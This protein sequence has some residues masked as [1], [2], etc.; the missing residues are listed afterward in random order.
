MASGPT[1]GELV[2]LLIGIGAAALLVLLFSAWLAARSRRRPVHKP[3]KKTFDH[4]R[5]LARRRAPATVA[6]AL[7]ELVD[8]PVGRAVH[9]RADEHRA[10]VTLA[11][12]RSQPCAQAAGYLA[13]LFESAWAHEVLVTHP[14]CAG[15]RGGE[16]AYVVQRG[17]VSAPAPRAAAASIPGSGGERRRW[18]RA[19][20]DVP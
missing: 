13:G 20:A 11:R 15:D 14:Q 9:A 2:A 6:A 12:R 4:G 7:D 1:G 16:C 17:P 3:P 5:R 8:A 19:R 18:P 10:E